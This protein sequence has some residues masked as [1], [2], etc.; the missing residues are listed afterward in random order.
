[1]LCVVCLCSFS[2][3]NYSL[4]L[5]YSQDIFYLLLSP[6][7]G[8]FNKNSFLFVKKKS[9]VVCLKCLGEYFE[10]ETEN[11]NFEQ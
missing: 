5:S 9:Q 7:V 2:I 11:Q 6:V 10:K 4:G 1:M 3:K 8:L